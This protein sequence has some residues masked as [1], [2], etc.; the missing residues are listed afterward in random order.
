MDSGTMQH[1][2]ANWYLT[3]DYYDDYLKYQ[4]GSGKVLLLYKKGIF[5]LLLD[6]GF[7]KLTN[8]WYAPDLGVNLM[9]TIQLGEKDVEI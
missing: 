2:I 5:F 9:S 1:F 7:L 4:T 8:V 3:R 6:N